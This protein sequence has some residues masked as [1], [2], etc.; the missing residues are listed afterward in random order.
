[1]T[2]SSNS[3]VSVHTN[4]YYAASAVGMRDYPSLTESE[5]CDVCV[6][7][8]GYTG[9]STALNLSERGFDSVVLEANK[10]GWGAPRLIESKSIICEKITVMIR[11]VIS[12]A[13]KFR[14]CWG[15]INI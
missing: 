1:M 2:S 6:I 7:G 13:P 4:S 10:V 3:T 14:G 12:S 15:L 11:Y 5:S 9:L 8:G